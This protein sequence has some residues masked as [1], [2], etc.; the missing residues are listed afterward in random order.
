MRYV[1]RACPYLAPRSTILAPA[2]GSVLAGSTVKFEWTEALGATA[3]VLQVGPAVNWWTIY[4]GNPG[5]RL[6]A[7]LTNLP[8]D[9]KP[10]Y[11]RLWY[12]INGS[13]ATNYVDN[14]VDA[15]YTAR[16]STTTP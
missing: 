7:T 12:L 16:S 10:V 3:Y 4:N 5:F 2:P 11:V 14:R 9:G 15:T 13:W 8:T 1:K 6:H